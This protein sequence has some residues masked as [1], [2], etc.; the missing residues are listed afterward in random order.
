MFT[1][2]VGVLAVVL[3]LSGC[4]HALHRGEPMRPSR[5]YT[6]LPADDPLQGNVV[7]VHDPSMARRA[8]GTYVVFD[9]D[10]VF[11][12]SKHYLEMRCS[13]DLRVWHGCGYVFEAMPQ[14]VR[15]EFP[16][17]AARDPQLW[18]PDISF[19]HGS[20]HL[21]YSA[22]KLGSQHSAI[23]L[24]TNPTLD[25]RDPRYRWTDH[26]VV[27]RSSH[28]DDFNAI[29]ANVVVSKDVGGEAGG[30]LPGVKREPRVWLNYGSFWNGIFQVELDPATGA[31]LPG[32][33]RY[34][35]A[36]QPTVR[37][38]AL[39]GAAMA[40]H[41]GWFYLFASVGICCAIPI[42]LDSYQQIVG[43][44]RSVHGPFIAEDGSALLRGGGTVLL[45]GD[46]HWLGPGGGSVWQSS[47]EQTT[48]LS[49]HALH[50]RENGALDL[51]VEGVD[52][53]EDWPV[54]RPLP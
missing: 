1:V 33:K 12:H 43:R 52:W 44:S 7:P 42:E 27:L 8:D 35:L 13:Q 17:V 3:T 26:G 14:W 25:P 6:P 21:Y 9:T 2:A 19:F 38:G 18:A 15:T 29:D 51:W 48:L 23:A 36:Q 5:F 46:E 22:S 32:G 34:H 41:D 30:V 20:W 11:L 37:G 24:A 16:E 53:R 39:E 28:G 31:P 47:D 10:V 45:T 50:R 4:S 49:F 40:S 54:L